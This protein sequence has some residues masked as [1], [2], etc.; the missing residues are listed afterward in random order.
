QGIGFLRGA[1]AYFRGGSGTDDIPGI[2]NVDEATRQAM[3]TAARHDYAVLK[4]Q[5]ELMAVARAGLVD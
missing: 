3:I 2:Q 1:V 5:T 4:L